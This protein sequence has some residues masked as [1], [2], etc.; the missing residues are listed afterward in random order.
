MRRAP[1]AI[2]TSVLVAAAVAGPPQSELLVLPSPRLTEAG[3]NLA[4]GD[5]NGDGLIDLAVV[6]GAFSTELVILLHSGLTLV[7]TEE[8]FELPQSLE[9]IAA[10]DFDADG[11][12]DLAV[13]SEEGVHL[14]WGDGAGA[15]PDSDLVEVAGEP[16][17]VITLDLDL[18]GDADLALTQ[19][20]EHRVATR[21]NDGAGGFSPGPA[22]EVGLF[23]IDV[24]A[25]DVD[26]D[27]DEDLLVLEQIGGALRVVRN[28]GD[29]LVSLQTQDGLDQPRTVIA[30][31]VT[32]EG[33]ADAVVCE[34]NGGRVVLY[35]GT[36]A[37]LEPLEAVRVGINP[38]NAAAADLDG[39]GLRDLAVSVGGDNEVAVLRNLGGGAAFEVGAIEDLYSS[40][41]ALAAQDVDFDGDVDLLVTAENGTDAILLGDGVGGFIRPGKFDAP[42]FPNHLHLV[43]LDG[44]GDL[45][46]AMTPSH[47]VLNEDGALGE[48]TLVGDTSSGGQDLA[49]EDLDGDGH[50]DLAIGRAFSSPPVRRYEVYLND[51]T[52]SFSLLLELKLDFDQ[53]PRRVATADLDGDGDPDTLISLVNNFPYDEFSLLLLF[54]AG[55]A[56][57]E[58]TVEVPFKESLSL[59]EPGDFDQDGN[60]DVLTTLDGAPTVLF[61]DGAGNLA[62]GPSLDLGPSSARNMKLGDIDRDGDTDAAVILSSGEVFVLLND[63]TRTFS[64]IALGNFVTGFAGAHDLALADL[65]ADGWPDI[66]VARTANESVVLLNAADT[67]DL[68]GPPSFEL[69]AGYFTFDEPRSFA[70]GDID[71]D[72]RRDVVAAA[73]N[74]HLLM[75]L[76]G[77]ADPA[78]GADFDGDG[79]AGVLDFVAF[80]E[81]FS[82]GS[83]TA[84][85]DEDGGLS[86]L[87]FVCFQELFQEGCE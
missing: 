75:T 58:R 11:A 16:R 43:D 73:T 37:G 60:V 59:L 19:W 78:C 68:G 10:A 12:L 52:G 27:G 50:V 65:S 83:L 4:R 69:N 48:P 41:R 7:K 45:D 3:A 62:P 67:G 23:P 28:D 81:A 6:Q 72:G 79:T 54:N 21:V 20:L 33:A 32:G 22:L 71:G 40:P 13:T 85:C 5:F 61:G 34:T 64:E 9:D 31:E 82:G 26:L 14:L 17:G 49:V 86:V 18:D 8:E 44:D 84:D 76:P 74:D 47:V 63:G 36:G 35:R 46:A 42:E 57:I 77:L 2:A 25:A 39:D 66:A 30:A 87:D 29:E 51:G 24:A 80:Q 55:D 53:V 38:W 15:F 1:A 70:T 56:T